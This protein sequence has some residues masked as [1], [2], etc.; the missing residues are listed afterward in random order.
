MR[1]FLILITLVFIVG[2]EQEK[3]IVEVEQFYE[4]EETMLSENPPLIYGDGY[5]NE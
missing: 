2:C 5:I 3:T 4:P 1:R